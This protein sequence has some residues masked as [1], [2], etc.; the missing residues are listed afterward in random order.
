MHLKQGPDAPAGTLDALALVANNSHEHASDSRGGYTLQGEVFYLAGTVAHAAGR[1]LEDILQTF[2]PFHKPAAFVT[3]V[4][5]VCFHP[6]ARD[7]RCAREF[8]VLPR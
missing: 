5:V 7:Q 1:V 2:S 8:E 3:Q 6:K 4:G